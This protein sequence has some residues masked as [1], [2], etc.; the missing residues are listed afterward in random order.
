MLENLR[1]IS[2]VIPLDFPRADSFAGTQSFDILSEELL[3]L[4]EDLEMAA[5]LRA[6]GWA[7]VA[8]PVLGRARGGDPDFSQVVAR[9]GRW[10]LAV[11]GQRPGLMPTY[12]LFF[13][14]TPM[15]LAL[16]L[17]GAQIRALQAPYFLPLLVMLVAM[18]HYGATLVRVYESRDDRRA[19]TIF[20]VWATLLLL[21]LFFSKTVP[22]FL[23]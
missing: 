22:R 18:P 12:P 7:I 17:F 13:F 20:S 9:F 23:S 21:G 4:A 1:S 19:Y 10:M 16:A 2:G 11:R 3:D 8:A 15:V 6:T 5:R 14:A